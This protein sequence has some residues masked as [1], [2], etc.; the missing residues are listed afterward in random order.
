MGFKE[1]NI[2]AV[3]IKF[4]VILWKNILF[5]ISE[6]ILMLKKRWVTKKFFYKSV[7]FNFYLSRQLIIF[8]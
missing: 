5:H 7:H 2:H 3:E 1:V 6:M 4:G 8:A